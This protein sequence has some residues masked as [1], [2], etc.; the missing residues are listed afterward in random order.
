[1]QFFHEGFYDVVVSDGC[2]LQFKGIAVS[3]D[4]V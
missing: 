4:L 3:V 1:M 2:I